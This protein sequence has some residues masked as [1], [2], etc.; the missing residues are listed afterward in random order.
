MPLELG[1]S[2]DRNYII[3]IP[4][5]NGYYNIGIFFYRNS[6][7]L[8]F[9]ADSDFPITTNT[10][11]IKINM[12]KNLETSKFCDVFLK[13]HNYRGDN[14]DIINQFDSIKEEYQ[15]DVINKINESII[16]S[17]IK[18]NDKIFYS[19]VLIYGLTITAYEKEFLFLI[20]ERQH[21]IAKLKKKIVRTT[22]IQ[23]STSQS[24]KILD[25]FYDDYKKS[26]N[27]N[28]NNSHKRIILSEVD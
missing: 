20:A 7:F 22:A 4:F 10:H 12:F 27:I 26:S 11:G 13:L 28:N 18:Y 1:K 23:L 16:L 17:K 3:R 9:R 15:V 8:L 25:E 14:L 2:F 19:N 24:L 6:N 21:I 5:L